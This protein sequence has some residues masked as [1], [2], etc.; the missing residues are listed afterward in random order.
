MTRDERASANWQVQFVARWVGIPSLMAIAFVGL[1]GLWHAWVFT[2][3]TQTWIALSAGLVAVTLFAAGLPIAWALLRGT[4]PFAARAALSLWV[5]CLLVNGAIMVSF[6]SHTPAPSAPWAWPEWH[7]TLFQGGVTDTDELDIQIEEC[8]GILA[9]YDAGFAPGA[10]AWQRREVSTPEARAKR[11]MAANKLRSLE[12]KRYGA[13][14]TEVAPAAPLQP[15]T[16]P[17]WSLA[18]I[19]LIMWACSGLGLLISASSLAAIL[20]EK[21]ATVR[22]EAENEPAP[23][24]A[25]SPVTYHPGESADGFETWATA[26]VSRLQGGRIRPGEAHASYL[27][28]CAR[29]DSAAPLQPQEFGRR[30]RAWLA[31]TYGLTGH[32]SN[33]TVYEGVTLAPLAAPITAPGMNGAYMNG[34]A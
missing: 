5:A 12:I 10:P 22:L 34:A 8:R 20:T 19:T 28:F 14:I 21:A 6:A 13:P 26:C 25:P 29:N 30:L 31:D 9:D 3:D 1:A 4:N 32:H 7:W 33:G 27:T 17:G 18:A 23:Q 11:A 16:K 2:S 15:G 24:P